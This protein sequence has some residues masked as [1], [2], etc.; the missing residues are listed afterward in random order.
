MS[1]ATTS[2][3]TAATSTSSSGS[4]SGSSGPTSSPLLFFV[5]LGFGVVFTN[6]WIIVGVK[7]CFRYNRNRQRPGETGDP[8]DLVA[9]PRP[10]R[11]RREKKLMPIDEVNERFPS[12][13]YK[14]W[15]STRAE[16]G[17]PTAGGVTS[18]P[19]RAPSMK[20]GQDT[21]VSVPM[22]G[23]RTST[24][25]DRTGTAGP[26]NQEP[27]ES[28]GHTN[29]SGKE[30]EAKLSPPVSP[31]TVRGSIFA[32]SEKKT[33]EDEGPS[34]ENLEHTKTMASTTLGDGRDDD[35]DDDEEDQ[36]HSAVPNEL[37]NN[38]GDAC[39]ICLDNIEDNDDIRGLTCGHAFHS[40]CL[41]PWLTTRRA[42]C[43]L[44]K[45][46]YYTPKPRTQEEEARAAQRMNLPQSPQFAYLGGHGS[47]S[48]PRMVLPG[49]FMAIVYPDRRQENGGFPV[50]VRQDRPPRARSNNPSAVPSQPQENSWRSRLSRLRI[51]RLTRSSN[52]Q[53][54]DLETG[55][56]Q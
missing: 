28:L 34:L 27:S 15:R 41:D 35:Y 12:M 21:V 20:D 1:A 9:V 53:P 39:A 3:V 43:P 55:T 32:A 24:E 5:A 50:I 25:S 52:R 37:L 29:V 23:G 7:Y 45:A 40:P 2:A 14:V 8:I 42:C 56:A 26:P 19:S 22:V 36:I 13:K 17:L 46:D 33:A 51:P 16:E 54:R 4:G 18:P 11:R 38:P 47:T 49:R 44:C 6:L 30:L 10:H 31:T 48:R